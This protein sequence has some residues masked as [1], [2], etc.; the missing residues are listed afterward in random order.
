VC[1]F[2]K[3]TALVLVSAG[4][5]SVSSGATWAFLTSC[6]LNRGERCAS[7]KDRL[8][9]GRDPS[10]NRNL[11][12]DSGAECRAC[13]RRL[14]G[15]PLVFYINSA[16]RHRTAALVSSTSSANRHRTAVFEKSTPLRLEGIESFPA[17][18]RT[19]SSS[20][21]IELRSSHSRRSRQDILEVFLK[22]FFTGCSVLCGEQR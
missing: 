5:S 2:N 14:A 17:Q 3:D 7:L 4:T 8:T 11:D 21:I 22:K 1:E 6:K 20:K 13:H 16:N 19:K 18:G 15:G 12:D 9:N 10:R